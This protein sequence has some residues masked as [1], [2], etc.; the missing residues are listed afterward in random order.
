MPDVRTVAFIAS[1][2]Q[3]NDAH[4]NVAEKNVNKMFKG[5]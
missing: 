2:K 4:Q 1:E 5:R 3:E